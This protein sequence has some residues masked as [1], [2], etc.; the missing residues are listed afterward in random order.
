MAFIISDNVEGG[1]VTQVLEEAL[2]SQ[3]D[4][5]IICTHTALLLI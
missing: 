2:C 1:T 5:V 3:N 4:N